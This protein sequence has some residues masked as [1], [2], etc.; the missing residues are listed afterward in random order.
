MSFQ[1]LSTPPA[2]ETQL[3]LSRARDLISVLSHECRTPLTSIK[4]FAETLLLHDERLT[5]DQRKQFLGII[6]DQ[7]D[8]LIRLTESLLLTYSKGLDLED[9][10]T[11]QH[12]VLLE[13]V[14]RVL[15]GFQGR[16]AQ[17][18]GRSIEVSFDL[19]SSL[20]IWADAD[21]L[22]EV[23]W[24]LLDNAL[25]YGDN[26][27]PI[28]LLVQTRKTES[29]REA[30]ITVENTADPIPEDKQ[31]MLFQP[32]CRMDNPLS[33]QQEGVGL[34]LYLVRRLVEAMGGVL[35]L[36]CNPAGRSVA[37]TLVF[38]VLKSSGVSKAK[39]TV[40]SSS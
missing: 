3:H 9:S 15:K 8:R 10:L 1:P 30:L 5:S 40:D 34:G 17:F 18:S 14:E 22:E 2:E 23:L 12:I 11:P 29:G 33:R 4:G 16:L 19:P 7:S 35:S 24:N 36:L 25:K 38:P 20:A 13:F 32:F 28:R 26:N 27:T 39:G 6:R 37:F 31:E 21:R